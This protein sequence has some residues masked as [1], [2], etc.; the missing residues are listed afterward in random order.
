MENRYLGKTLG[1]R[2]KAAG[3]VNV[4]AMAMAE[5][6]KQSLLTLLMRIG[7]PADAAEAMVETFLF[8][9]SPV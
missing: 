3:L 9:H 4:F 8:Q 1:Q 2:L 6:D 7:Y 5:Q